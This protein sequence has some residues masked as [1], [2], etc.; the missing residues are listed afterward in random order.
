MRKYLT[1]LAACTT[2]LCAACEKSDS[3]EKVFLTLETPEGTD[4]SLITIG[5]G[6]YSQK[7]TVKTNTSWRVEKPQTDGWLT[8]RPDH[9]KGDASIVVTAQANDLTDPRQTRL[10]FYADDRE[11]HTLTVRQDAKK[12]R[13]P[14]IAVKPESPGIIPSSGGDL[15]LTVDTNTDGWEYAIKGENTGWLSE[16]TKNAA[17]VTF[18]A[19]RNLS[20]SKQTASVEFTVP[21]HPDLRQ[22]V[23]LTQNGYSAGPSA[24]LLDVV[25]DNDGSATDVSPMRHTVQKI[26]GSSMM[27][28]YNDGYEHYV[29]RFN[30][31][32]GSAAGSGYYKINYADN[33]Q[34]Q[35]ALADGHTL[36]TLFMFDEEPR[37]GTEVKMFSSMEGGGTGFLLAKEKGEITFLPNLS[38]GGWQWTRS[39]IVP[40]KG[41]YYH[42]VGVWDKNKQKSYV[43]VNGALKGSIDATGNFNFPNAQ[44]CYWFCIGGDASPSAA[45]NAWK[46]DVVIARVYDDPLTADQ[47]AR[48]WQQVRDREPQSVLQI[49]DIFFLSGLEVKSGS[50]YRVSGKGFQSGDRVRLES[51][52]A[53]S[54]VFD[55]AATA[56]EN[57][58]S[59]EIPTGFVSG[60]YRMVLMRGDAVYPLG[61]TELTLSDNPAELKLPQVIAHRGYHTVNGA[62]HNSIASLKGARQLGVYG[63]EADF[64]ITK[65][66]VIVAHHDPAIN[67]ITIEDANYSDIRN[68][69]LSNGEKIPTLAAFLDEIGKDP[70]LKLVIEIKSHKTDANNARAVDAIVAMVDERSL[71][72]RVDY[73]AFSY[74]VCQ[75]LAEKAPA[76]TLIGYLS[77]DKAPA[78]MDPKI[79][80]I[81]YAMGNLRSNPQWIKEAHAR[82]MT[83]NVWTVNSEQD[84][85][86][87][88]AMGV[89]FITTDY[90]DK[91]QEIVKKLSE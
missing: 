31:A 14:F 37:I 67:G 91:L 47:V 85:T 49:S 57:Y 30:H 68:L 29:A 12:E 3:R 84:M 69:T 79:R 80:C 38:G 21:D 65:D 36:E 34:F 1:L 61:V 76:G 40:E 71:N 39:G 56:T 16:K 74:Y 50:H 55:C 5:E 64:Y 41:K 59:I 72:D 15:T 10:A 62:S 44:S 27:T 90:P 81:D 22:T 32:P 63:S 23:E 53:E 11:F 78:S 42:V 87:F 48:L 88:I 77:G 19:A 18:T 9:G 73:I 43:Y 8:V 33:R 75:K 6:S 51:M 60:E 46:G 54:A 45:G 26:S 20:E 66:G 35:D 2:I 13:P 83:V 7:F 25:F 86:D 89:D 24:D 58:V 82:G 17:G 4:P 28:Y 52:T 70:N